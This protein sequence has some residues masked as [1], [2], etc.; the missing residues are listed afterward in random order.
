MPANI[1]TSRQAR[2]DPLFGP[3]AAI[4]AAL[5]AIGQDPPI[6]LCSRFQGGAL[7]RSRLWFNSFREF[8]PVAFE[9]AGPREAGVRPHDRFTINLTHQPQGGSSC[10]SRLCAARPPDRLRRAS[11]TARPLIGARCPLLITSRQ[12]RASG[13]RVLAQR[14]DLGSIMSRPREN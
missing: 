8:V 10:F 5:Q 7:V 3:D 13:P 1:W 11:G 6:R 2:Q 4:R 12:R 9:F 14:V